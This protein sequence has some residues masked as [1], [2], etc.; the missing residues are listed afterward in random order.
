MQKLKKKIP[1]NLDL[2]LTDVPASSIPKAL[3]CLHPYNKKRDA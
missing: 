2:L 1:G 3:Q